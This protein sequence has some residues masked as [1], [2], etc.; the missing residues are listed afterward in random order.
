MEANA[1]EALSNQ[2]DAQ[3]VADFARQ[4]LAAKGRLYGDAAQLQCVPIR[5]D[6]ELC[7]LHFALRGP[8]EVLL[9][10]VWDASTGALWCY[11]SRGERFL[12][13]QTA[14]G[15]KPPKND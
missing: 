8:R 12:R 13:T 3:Q 2:F 14:I 4:T 9:T 1:T 11:D 10:A 5:R 7:G 6:G 15:V